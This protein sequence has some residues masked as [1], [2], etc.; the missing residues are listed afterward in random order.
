MNVT[1][2]GMPIESS[3]VTGKLYHVY[4]YTVITKC[5][6]P[7]H[8]LKN[9]RYSRESKNNWRGTYIARMAQTK[10]M[11]RKLS[12]GMS[13]RKRASTKEGRQER[14]TLKVVKRRCR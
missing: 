3:S 8:R 6:D 2:M 9:L 14:D 13:S 10:Q 5:R 11:P 4:Q 1:T 7:G 12:G